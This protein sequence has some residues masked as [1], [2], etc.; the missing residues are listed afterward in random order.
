MTYLCYSDTL[1]VL[2]VMHDVALTYQKQSDPQNHAVAFTSQTDARS[3][4]CTLLMSKGPFNLA[5]VHRHLLLF[6]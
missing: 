5:L 4:A 6:F 1:G 2:L 3:S